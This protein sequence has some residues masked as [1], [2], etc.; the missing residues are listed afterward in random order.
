MNRLFKSIGILTTLGF[1]ILAYQ[2]CSEQNKANGTV[3]RASESNNNQPPADN[4]VAPEPYVG[5]WGFK[6]VTVP[7][8]QI[9]ANEGADLVQLLSQLSAIG[10][11]RLYLKAGTY[12]SNGGTMPA[13]VEIV[14]EGMG[15]TI[16]QNAGNLSGIFIDSAARNFI[17]RDLTID[18]S[19]NT[20]DCIH[21]SGGA[22]NILIENVEIIGSNYSGI[23]IDNTSPAVSEDVTLNNVYSHGAKVYNGVYLKGVLNAS[24]TNSQLTN[25]QQFGAYI[26]NSQNIDLGFNELTSNVGGSVVI[27][28]SSN[29]LDHDNQQ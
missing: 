2:N 7:N 10:G 11:G 19:S 9:S 15:K 4:N 3:A 14:G 24:V 23:A 16:I 17:I 20:Q 25:N 5:Q 18:A 21:I 28:N 26:I 6:P 12:I 22:D 29:V 1:C 27:E 8:N 13:N